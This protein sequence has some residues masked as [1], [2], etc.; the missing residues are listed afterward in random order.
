MLSKPCMKRL[1]S[2]R[3]DWVISWF[4]RAAARRVRFLLSYD[5][6][7]RERLVWPQGSQLS[8]R[9]AR[10]SVACLSSHSRGIGPQDMLKGECRGLSRSEAGNLRELLRVPMESQ[11]YCGVG[12]GLSGH[13]WVWC[14]GR[15]PLLEL[16]WELQ[17][18]SPVLTWVSGCVCRFKQG[19]RS[20]RVWRHGTLLSS[21]V[22]EGVSGLQPS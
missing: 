11:E 3:D 2:S 9:V 21:R 15:G 17:S 22:V 14:N 5:G 20:R 16:R 10:G 1:P 12:R 6:E 19:V 13:H 8:F 4:S 18:S 7:L